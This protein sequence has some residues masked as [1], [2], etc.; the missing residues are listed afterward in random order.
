LPSKP[1]PTAATS[2]TTSPRWASWSL[3]AAGCRP[4]TTSGAR[5]GRTKRCSASWA[6]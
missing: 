3:R 5:Y 4:T 2:S 6:K 1:T